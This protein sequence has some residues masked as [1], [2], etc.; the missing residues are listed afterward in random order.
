MGYNPDIYYIIVDGYARGDVLRDALRFRQFARFSAASN[1]AA[2]WSTTAAG[3]NYNWTF[4][5]LA[6]SLNF[7]YLQDIAAPLFC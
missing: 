3:A 4:L 5:S 7:D 2:S 6:S 1:S